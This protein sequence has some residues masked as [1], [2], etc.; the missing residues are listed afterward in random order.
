[1]PVNDKILYTDYNTIRD[2]IA[3]LLGSGSGSSGYG[4]TVQSSRVTGA[5][6]TA[7]PLGGGT[8][9]NAIRTDEYGKLRYDIINIYRH[10]YGT[11]PT[12]ADPQ[13]GQ[14][15]RYVTAAGAVT[16]EY[17][18]SEYGIAE[19]N[20][21]SIAGSSDPYTQF[22]IFV[23][24]LANARFTVATS[25]SVTNSLG[26]VAR[27]NA[28]G[29]GNN[30]ISTRIRISWTNP[31]MARW[32]FNSGG[33]FRISASRSGGS[34]NSQ[35][36]SWTNLL[37]GAGTQTF[38]A[39]LPSSTLTGTGGQ[40]WYQL[41]N[42]Y[43]NWYTT[44]ASTPYGA[45]QFRIAARTLDGIVTNN[46]TGSSGGIDFLVS[47]QDNYNDPVPGG[48]RN[49][50]DFPPG[51]SVDGTLQV[52]ISERRASGI[53]QPEPG[54]GN[55]TIDAPIVVFRGGSTSNLDTID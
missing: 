33:Q 17:G 21:T 23:T 31:N 49:P 8:G 19:Y 39:I 15:I 11:D 7:A 34:V 53:L 9:A 10:I 28:W 13:V 50:A 3:N 29:G 48:G 44:T 42:L 32:F 35:N 4:Q 41:T 2:A 51:D 24:D 22:S 54:T 38:S 45:N 40:N 37:A 16:A 36:T 6:G 14:L 18:I 1:M 27:T 55:F 30:T 20:A 25:Q 46:N 52:S 12:P 43:Q 5:S 47:F 26:G